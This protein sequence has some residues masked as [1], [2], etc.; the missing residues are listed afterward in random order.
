MVLNT[1]QDCGIYFVHIPE[2][3]TVIIDS[4]KF[5][6]FFLEDKIQKI[7][8]FAIKIEGSEK[9][10]IRESVKLSKMVV[11][12]FWCYRSNRQCLCK[13]SPMEFM[14]S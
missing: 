5:K 14:T 11:H 1:I 7:L 6:V 8:E 13:S 10:R 2:Q 12:N 9:I 4:V 3:V